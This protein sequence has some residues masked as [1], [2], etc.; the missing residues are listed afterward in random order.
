MHFVRRPDRDRRSH[1]RPEI[2]PE[3]CTGCGRCVAACAPH[4]LSLES[5]RWEKFAVL[6]DPV[7]CT[8]CAECAL[9]CP[10][11]AIRMRAPE[12]TARDAAQSQTSSA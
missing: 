8:G 5:V 3:R 10:F 7:H 6:H 11:G 2:D 12:A 1:R 9:V 4:V